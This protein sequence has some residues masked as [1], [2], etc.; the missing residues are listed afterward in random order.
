[1]GPEGGRDQPFAPDGVLIPLLRQIQ[2]GFA[3]LFAPARAD[4]EMDNEVRDFVNRRSAELQREGVPYEVAVRRAASE[5]GSVTA[6][7]EEVRASGWEHGV[8][9]VLSDVRY[10]LRRL[11]RDPVFT[12]VAALTLAVGIG[13]ATAIFSAVNPI[14]FRAL[15]Y[16]GADRIVTISDRAPTGAAAE[17][18]FGTYEELASRS[19]SFETLSAADLWRPSLTGTDEAERLQGQRVSASYFHTLGVLPRVGRS[20]DTAEDAPG[21]AR[22]AVLSDRLIKRRFGGSD[23]VVGAFIT[24]NGEPHTVIGV[25]APGFIDILSPSTD[26]WAPLQAQPRAPPNSREWG[27]HYRIVGRLK[28]GVD[29]DVARRELATIA[30]QP[31][32]EF[33][34]VLWAALENGL[35]VRGLQEDVTASARPALLA[36]VAAAAMLLLIACVNV[37]NLL[38]ARSRRRRAEFALRAALGAER[39]RLVRQLLTEAVMLAM[40]GGALAFVVAQMGVGALVALSPPGLPNVDQVRVDAAAFGFGLIVTTIVGVA[41]GLMPALSASRA[42]VRGGMQVVSRTISGGRG[43]MRAALVVSEVALA[44]VLLVGAGL[45]VRSLDRLLAVSPGIQTERVLT[46][47]VVDAAGRNRTDQER[48]NFYEQ[49]LSAVQ[50]VPGVTGA[51]LTSQLPLSG[52]LDAYGFTFAA[53]PERQPGQ[54]GAAMR[55][56]ITSDY[57][58]VMGIP[59]LRGR[60]LD[61]SDRADAPPSFVI[62]ESLARQ[63]FGETDPIGQRV[64]FGPDSDGSRPWG[65]VVG[66]VGDVKQQSLASQNTAAFYV[67]S[68]QWRWVDP[69][70][71]LVVQTSGDAAAMTNAVRRAVW[72]VD[73]NKPITRVAT[74]EQLIWRTGSDRRFASVIYGTFA[75]AALLLA[76]VGLYGVVSGLVAERT[77]E[78]GIRSALGATRGEIVRGVLA[79]GLLVT[80]IGVII[81]LAGAFAT[82]QLLETL[83][84]GISRVD[85]STYAGVIA[86]LGSVAVVACWA[87]ARRAAA[88]DPA[89]TLRSE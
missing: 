71:S 20:F 10:A 25:M 73:R 49:A 31:I 2:R 26:I 50:N 11:R 36:V 88:V 52:D 82:S 13:A 85:V 32:T 37:A 68:A 80:T 84:Y 9:T 29:V 89:V 81:G 15:P 77:R 74:M 39:K 57:F 51:A 16:P 6:T 69:V 66:V 47:Q 14:L 64:R 41:V 3:A 43:T 75:I 63:T 79:N 38:L 58:G 61:E 35:L 7:R 4:A 18:T 59:L 42:D 23:S 78:F 17:P 60:L 56:S 19:R 24:L 86:L 28:A 22:V 72:S 30:S 21:A 1:V 45:L 27:H 5:I 54:D 83:L 48:L 62:S 33:P 67:S 53:F 65:T 55:Y 40:I 70:Q 76:A 87:P 46:M 12:L 34:R 44:L 8:D